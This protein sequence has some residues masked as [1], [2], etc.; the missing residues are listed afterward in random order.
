MPSPAP[1][2]RPTL[3]AKHQLLAGYE[4][5]GLLGR[6]GMGEVY[7]ARQV[8]MD[9]IVALKVLAPRLA[10]DP[11]FTARFIAEARAAGKLNHPNIVHVHDVGTAALPNGTDAYYFSMEL[12]EGRSLQ[13]VLDQGVLLDEERLGRAMIGSAQALAYAA[14]QG[15]VHRD[16]KPDNLL[17]TKDGVTK[18]ADLGLATTGGEEAVE[19]DASG[20]V[21]VMGTPRYMAPEQARGLAL[22]HRCDQYSLGATLFHLLTGQPPFDGTDGKSVMRAH[23]HDPVPDPQDLRPDVPEA[24]RQLCQRLMAKTPEERFPTA[25]DLVEAVTAAAE[26][27][28]LVALAARK[29]GIPWALIGAIGGGVVALGAVI[30]LLMGPSRRPEP[31]A[32]P[33]PPA[34]EV[35]PP[36]PEMPT[37]APVP[38]PDPTLAP[39]QVPVPIPP[40]RITPPAPSTPAPEDG[41]QKLS[42]RLHLVRQRLDYLATAPQ[43]HQAIKDLA[44]DPRVPQAKTLLALGTRGQEGEAILRAYLMGE[45]PQVTLRDG[46]TCRATRLSLTRFYGT[47]A[48]GTEIQLPRSEALASYGPL[49]AEA[50][51]YHGTPP[52]PELLAACRWWWQ[53]PDSAPGQGPLDQALN[54]LG[55]DPLVTGPTAP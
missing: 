16:V 49:F 1:E 7:R 10:Q 38:V 15:I 50:L 52:D 3:L 22:D 30:L 44:G 9:R 8:S 54:A 39:A 21:K 33:A 17:L 13:D 18:L 36:V 53:I 55:P 40:A 23:V 51:R 25:P 19:R 26:G 29:R 46:R 27:V 2:S 47:L 14:A 11:V 6:G 12:I 43:I 37:P 20:R 35:P 5:L 4:I 42:R 48:D 24:W 34:A 31:S 45:L 32:P 41:W 28:T